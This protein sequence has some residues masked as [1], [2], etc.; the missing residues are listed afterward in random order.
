MFDNFKEKYMLGNFENT[1]VE[2][3]KSFVS[4]WSKVFRTYVLTDDEMED[5]MLCLED[6]CGENEAFRKLFQKLV[7][8]IA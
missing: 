7:G 5:V 6:Y 2:D 4:K 3:L 8:V 1:I